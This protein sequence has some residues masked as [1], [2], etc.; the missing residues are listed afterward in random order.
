MHRTR[1]VV[2]CLKTQGTASTKIASERS[3]L[4]QSQRTALHV[5]IACDAADTA[6][7]LLENGAQMDVKDEVSSA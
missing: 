5:A 7:Y 2:A 6:V 3:T 4:A 1:C